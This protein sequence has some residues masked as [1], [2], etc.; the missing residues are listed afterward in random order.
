MRP[1]SPTVRMTTPRAGGTLRGIDCRS[2]TRTVRC[3]LTTAIG[4]APLLDCGRLARAVS[5]L[6]V[7]VHRRQPGDL[8][9]RRTAAL[10]VAEPRR[11]SAG[12]RQGRRAA[13]P[14]GG[15]E[16]AR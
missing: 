15:P 10:P 3:V 8:I 11:E 7:S 16:P 9:S 1:A 6:V 13:R 12:H 5:L 2:R 4:V 14:T